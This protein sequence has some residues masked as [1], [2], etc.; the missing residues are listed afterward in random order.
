M[1]N[2]PVEK[3]SSGAAWLPWLLGLIALVGLIW[4]GLE[5]FDNEPDADEIAGTED[6]VGL[7]DDVELGDDDPASAGVGPEANVTGEVTAAT[8]LAATDPSEFVGETY[9][10]T[11]LRVME[12]LGDVTFT[13]SPDGSDRM[14]LVYLEQELTPDVV[15]V[16]GRYDVN[17]GQMVE[18]RGTVQQLTAEDL[19]A[20]GISP[21]GVSAGDLYVRASALDISNA[22]L[23]QVEVD[24]TSV[25]E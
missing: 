20:W 17:A 7:I 19:S 12:V 24:D 22:D 21:T 9:T 11:G 4:L 18:V 14:M 23:D 2:I 1:A 3:N 15:G 25:A 8:L 16:E 13:V 10:L 5:L 6:N